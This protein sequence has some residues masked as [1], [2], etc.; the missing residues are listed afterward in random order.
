MDDSLERVAALMNAVA[1]KYPLVNKSDLSLLTD[2]MQHYEDIASISDI[3]RALKSQA[4]RSGLLVQHIIMDETPFENGVEKLGQSIEATNAALEELLMFSGIEGE[5]SDEKNGDVKEYTPD[6]QS[7]DEDGMEEMVSRFVSQQQTVL[8]D[9]EGCALNLEKGDTEARQMIQRILHTW[10]G[11]FGVL[12]LNVFSKFIHEVEEYLAANLFSADM[13]LRLKD[14]LSSKFL[15]LSSGK[16]SEITEAEKAY[17]LQKPKP[18]SEEPLHEESLEDEQK[19]DREIMPKSGGN[20]FDG[21]PSLMGDFVAES[22]EH[23]DAAEPMVLELEN[24]PHDHDKMNTIFR[25]CHTI[26]GVAGFLGLS[27]IS[28]LSHSIE[29]VMDLARKDSLILSPA[30]V[31]LLLESMDTLRTLVDIVEA[32]MNGESRD[33]PANV[34]KLCDRLS[35]PETLSG[36]SI[37]AENGR[38][39]EILIRRGKANAEDVENA[40]LTQKGGDARKIGEILLSQKKVQSRSIASALAS[41]RAGQ[42]HKNLEETIRVPVQRLD[43]LI[44]SIGEAVIAQSMVYSDKAMDDVNDLGLGKKIARAT[45]IMRQIQELSMSLRMVSIKGTFQKM[46]R[47]VRDLSRKFGK[48]IEFVTEGEDTELDKSVVENIGDPLIHMIRNALDH[49]VETLQDRQA[50]G[51]S[52]KATVTLRAYHKA[53]NVF[54]EIEDDGKGMDSDVILKKAIANGICKEGENYSD[55]EIL[56]FVFMPGFSTAQKVTDISGRGV[57]MDVVKRNIEMLRGSV[58]IQSEKGKG[59]LFTIRLPLTLAIINGMIIRLGQ[60]R[61]IVP[62]LSIIES[63]R[64]K[65]GQLETVAQRGEMVKVR[66]ELIRLIR[67]GAVFDDSASNALQPTDGIVLIVEDVMGRKAGLLVNE[68]LDQQQ[69][70]I[71]SLGEGVGDVQGITGGAIMNDGTVSLIVDIG[72][73]I[74]MANEMTI[75]TTF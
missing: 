2:I 8:E 13:A 74:K 21:D 51:K 52:P 19:E 60:Q 46:A 73:I 64:P 27:E 33:R 23:L 35:A 10:K 36:E 24:D 18:G 44:D 3:P 11:E 37:P 61:Y 32:Q 34:Q 12:G 54:I 17:V 38:L 45:Q 57:G 56:Q 66:G 25:A 75:S 65:V 5:S 15:L 50:A 1:A 48:D 39:G 41:Q 59:T 49:G 53:G 31:D 63:L 67:L 4:A 71:K 26:K 7:A 14:L 30:H 28:H 6:N 43:Q 69:V 47:L 29:H 72:G 16:Q 58:D 20:A 40:L 70:V 9:F 62:T 42:Q 55:K 68:I 22:R